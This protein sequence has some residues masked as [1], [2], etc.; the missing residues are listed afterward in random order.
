MS[1]EKKLEVPFVEQTT[2]TIKTAIGDVEVP[3]MTHEFC[4]GLAVTMQ[5]FGLFTVTHIKSGMKL[6]DAYE[7]SNSA[8]LLLSQFALIAKDNGFSWTDSNPQESIK[9]SGDKPVPFGGSTITDSNGTNPMTVK[10][11]VRHL[12]MMN[13]GG[14]VDEFPWEE[15]NTVDE[16]MKNLGKANAQ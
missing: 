8:L 3:A 7:R 13:F 9:K 2:V 11:W 5:P 15:N 16:A 10:E 1:E 14:I 4:P 12:R 6:C